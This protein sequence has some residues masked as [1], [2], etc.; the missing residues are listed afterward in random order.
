MGR[1]DLMRHSL[2][3]AEPFYYQK[4]AF[5]HEGHED[6]RRESRIRRLDASQKLTAEMRGERPL[7]TLTLRKPLADE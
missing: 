6:A 3:I 4:K 2:E 7:R 1:K 5:N